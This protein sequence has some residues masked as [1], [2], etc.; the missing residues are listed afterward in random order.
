MAKKNSAD[1]QLEKS[2]GELLITTSSAQKTTNFQPMDNYASG[3]LF[4]ATASTTVA[5]TTIETTIFP[6]GTGTK[7]LDA[8]F[9][10][11]AKTVEIELWGTIASTGTPTLRIKFKLGSTIVIDTTAATLSTITGTNIWRATATI[12]CRTAGG[13][14]TVFGQGMVSYHTGASG[15]AG[16]ASPNTTTSTIDTTTTQVIDVTAQW[17]TASAS[18]TITC[19]NAKIRISM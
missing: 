14:G 16:I 7:T 8:N 2:S 19:T 11:V 17:G 10:A 3:S 1:F 4:N 13:S 15:L 6:S 12:D 9:L 5:N 18:N